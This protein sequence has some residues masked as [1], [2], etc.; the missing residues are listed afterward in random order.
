MGNRLNPVQRQQ[1]L[2]ALENEDFDVVVI[3]GG[4]TGAGAALDAASRGLKTAIIEAQDWASGAS[5]RSTRLVR[6]GLRYLYNLDV[7]V[8]SDSIRERALL[9][10]VI[11]PHLVRLQPFL[12]PLGRGLVNQVQARSGI[13]MFQMLNQT[14]GRRA[15]PRHR[16]RS[17]A[18]VI[19]RFPSIS[20]DSLTGAIEFYDARVDDARLVIT[21]VRTAQE[22]GARAV[23]RAQVVRITRA[24]DAPVTGLVA[25]DLETGKEFQVRTRGIINATGV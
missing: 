21:L 24:E 9:L 19:K 5:S 1:D 2:A 10:N 7:K 17:R 14:V 8:V 22:Y 6:G 13:A 16:H 20:P 18:S 11:A 12:W 23:S 15:L 3:G 25:R 4:V